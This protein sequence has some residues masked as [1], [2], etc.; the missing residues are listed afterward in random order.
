MATPPSEASVPNHY[1]SKNP[2]PLLT[3]PLTQNT[4]LYFKSIQQYYF[5]LNNVGLLLSK[6]LYIVDLEELRYLAADKI[7]SKGALFINSKLSALY[8]HTFV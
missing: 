6:F 5:F 2:L 3:P 8:T 1:F 4:V 7:E